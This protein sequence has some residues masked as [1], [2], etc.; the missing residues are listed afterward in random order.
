VRWVEGKRSK[1]IVDFV[2]I[3]LLI[4]AIL[5]LPPIS[6]GQ[7]IADLGTTRISE[8]GGT[9]AD[10]DGTQ[11]VFM[12]GSVAQPFRATISSVPRVSFLEGS[13]GNELLEAAKAIPP[14]LVAKSPYYALK[15]RG[16]APSQSTWTMPIPNDSEPYETLDVYT[17]EPESQTW[18]WLP[19][20]IIREDDLI[21]T[22]SNAVPLSAMVMQT[23][24]NPALVAADVAQAKDLPAESQGALAQ[25][26]PTGLYLG[27]NGAIDGAVDATFD[28]AAGAY[29]VLPVIRNY[30]GPIVRSDLLANMLVDNAQRAAHI[31]N[32]VNLAVGNNYKGIDIDYRG[33][34]KNLRGEFNQFIKELAEKLDAQGKELSVRV[35]PAAQVADDRW[36]TGPYD[37]QTL[38]LLADTVK[39][40]APQDPNAYVPDGRLDALV[41]YAVGQ[42]NRSKLQFILGGQSMEQAGNY[43]LPKSYTDALQPLLGRI[44][45]DQTVVEPG[46]PLNLALVSS[47]PT[48][49]LVYDPNI[50]VYVYRYQDDQGNARTVWLE[51]A[52]SLSH[53]L[54]LLKQYNLQ[55]FTLEHLPADGLDT[56]LWS[57]MK[58]Y[59]QGR[60]QPIEN[61]FVVEWTLKGSD[62]QS[63]S[64]TRPLADSKVAFAAPNAAG[65]L[66]VEA[67]IKDRG[68]VIAR[69]SGD[70]IA[71]ATYTPVPT[72]TPMPTPTPDF[73][74]VTAKSSANVRSGPGTAY[75]KTGTLNA[76]AT[77]RVIGQSET[78]GWWQ[79]SFDGKEAWVS[80]DMVDVNG[81]TEIVA[82][83]QVAP[84]PTAV[85]VAA[86]PAAAKP[87]AA[88][89]G[90]SFPAAPGSFGY[91]V[92]IDPWGDRGRAVAAIK[93]MGFNW[94]K[95][96]I[97]WKTF[98]GSPGQRGFADD[99]I[100]ELAG[101]G[102]NVLASIVKAPDWAR[103]GNTDR[104]VEGPPADPQTYADYVA[105]FAAHNKGK[106]KA[107]EVWNEQNLWYEWGHEPLD[108]GRYVDLLC[109]AYR[110]IKSADP[111]ISVIGGALTPTGVNDGST[112]IDD[113]A[114]LQRMY[115]AGAKNC[116]DGIGAHPSG[117]NNPP[118]AK[119]G[120]NNPAEPSFKNHPSFFFRDTME[121]YRAVMVANGDAGKRVW[122]TEFG[123]A[124]SGSP[125]PGYEYAA[126][127]TEAEQAGFIV[128]AY[129]MAKN[130][131][132][133]GP[134]FLWNLDYNVTQPSTELA[135][136]GIMGRAAQGAL[137]G[138]PK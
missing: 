7:R 137:G 122:P 89:S 62:G 77:Y 39:V 92:Q 17:W 108:P 34:D 105:A 27:G 55:G 100:N 61:N 33:L 21:E 49:G 114:Y 83:V 30:E 126:Q 47:K 50:G 15:L 57:L 97:P 25:V 3:P 121:R 23:N 123:W 132:W 41:R 44:A 124:S 85:P 64:E 117:Y 8:A 6:A 52:A 20:N 104:S 88:A 109:R 113:V 26:Q 73:V 129:Q 103:P 48:S 76:G 91:G 116:M 94:V 102:L 67:L 75:A 13:A 1:R 74:E 131:G 93:G 138:M 79:I 96:Q 127:N 110:A 54:D 56:D 125:H 16:E 37:W 58:N 51:N 28:Q 66:Q 60:V 95:V 65:A 98:E 87:A 115:A 86:K 29:A 99:I 9:I 63:V 42:I 19:H 119:F 111:S 101:S 84:P 128:Q 72:P 118:D 5:L 10:P 81:P 14:A 82:V 43:L 35:E 130:W 71:V 107:I 53:K 22:T 59:Q 4:I 24:P 18:Q 90:G 136:F 134:M 46:Q 40:P 70:A 11:V 38:G 68:Q 31:E 78:P 112:A 32:L 36:E 106:V 45:A 2:V 133:V 12:P 120:Y 135:A 69:Q 80:A